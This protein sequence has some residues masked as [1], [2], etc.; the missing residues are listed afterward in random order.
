MSIKYH[1]LN[2]G[3][4][5]G[6]EGE[7]TQANLNFLCNWDF[8]DP[9]NSRGS[10]QYSSSGL[11]YTLDGWQSQ[12]NTL[13]IV[14]GGIQIAQYS[15]GTMGFFMQ[16]YSTAWT[17]ALKNKQFMVSMIVDGVLGY[18]IMTIPSTGGGPEYLMVNGVGARFYNY[19]TQVAFTVDIQQDTAAH[20]IQGVKIEVGTEETLVDASTMQFIRPMNKDEENIKILSGWV[21]NA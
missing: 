1:D 6:G 21:L 10:T 3:V 8:T 17:D 19:G 9:I 11:I 18:M 12:G 15:S 2:V 16:R 5:L 4:T 7:S 20:I 14:P 13:T